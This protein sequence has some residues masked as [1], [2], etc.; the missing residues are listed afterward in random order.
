MTGARR[1]LPRRR[2]SALSA[3][4]G[5]ELTARLDLAV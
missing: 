3:R 5:A 1:I 4:P 2:T